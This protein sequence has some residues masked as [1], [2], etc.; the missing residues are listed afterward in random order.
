MN[1]ADPLP[2]D[3][4]D[5]IAARCSRLAPESNACSVLSSVMLP[6]VAVEPTFSTQL[7]AAKSPDT[8]P[9]TSDEN[10]LITSRRM[11]PTLEANATSIVC[12]NEGE[13]AALPLWTRVR[14]TLA[15]AY[16]TWPTGDP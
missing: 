2:V 14:L 7:P 12:P 5:Q 11:L 8:D 15:N 9:R 3:A 13:L 10:A 6:T 16:P 4:Q 1:V